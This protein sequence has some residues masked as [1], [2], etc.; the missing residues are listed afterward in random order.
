M[1]L[2]AVNPDA[3][4]AVWMNYMNWCRIKEVLLQNMGSK[5]AL[6]RVT[7]SRNE[8]LAFFV[9]RNHFNKMIRDQAA[10]EV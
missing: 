10:A 1:R 4:F 8:N 5:D 6:K 7:D 3:V 9:I 2:L